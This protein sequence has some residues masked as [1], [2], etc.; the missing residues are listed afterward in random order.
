[1]KSTIAL[2]QIR[3]EN[4]LKHEECLL[5]RHKTL[6]RNTITTSYRNVSTLEA[7]TYILNYILNTRRD[8]EET[9]SISLRARRRKIKPI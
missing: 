5:I 9:I 1:M 3:N 8:I 6:E 4:L 2:R 7:D